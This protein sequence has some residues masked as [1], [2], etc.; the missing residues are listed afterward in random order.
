M[1]TRKLLRFSAIAISQ[2]VDC[3][4]HASNTNFS[5]SLSAPE[6]IENALSALGGETAIAGIQSVTYRV[7]E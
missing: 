7:P 4:S 2:A 3:F 1:A 5:S 6:L